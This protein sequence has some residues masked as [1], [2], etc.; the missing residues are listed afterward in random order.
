MNENTSDEYVCVR[1]QIVRV[2]KGWFGLKDTV[3][4]FTTVIPNTPKLAE[5]IFRETQ[6]RLRKYGVTI[7]L[8]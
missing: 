3:L 8:E 2:K 1:V 7:D 6:T 4:G 5:K